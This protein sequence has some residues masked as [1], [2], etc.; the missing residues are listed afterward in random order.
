VPIVWIEDALDRLVSDGGI[1][2]AATICW[3]GAAFAS[4][5]AARSTCS[6]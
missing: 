6:T 3:T 1:E 4:Q 2:V 5:H